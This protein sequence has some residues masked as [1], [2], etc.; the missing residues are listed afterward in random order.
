MDDQ[1]LNNGIERW[2]CQVG[3]P[4]LIPKWRWPVNSSSFACPQIIAGDD[5]K[6]GPRQSVMTDN[7]ITPTQ[8]QHIQ[9]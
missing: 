8:F 5:R 4:V 2:F 9:N 3:S 6:G 7:H 1:E